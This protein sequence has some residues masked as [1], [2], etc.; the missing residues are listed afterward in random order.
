MSNQ[1][2]NVL[3][4]K[5][6]RSNSP[7]PSKDYQQLQNEST[8]EKEF[9]ELNLQIEK[10][11]NCEICKRDLRSTIKFISTSKLEFCT[12]C[13][14]SSKIESSNKEDY[15]VENKLNFPIFTEEWSASEEILLLTG[16]L[17]K[18]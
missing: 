17:F 1:G 7:S 8:N 10:K 6:A 3:R 2:Q 15:V 4:Q 11:S 13:F 9:I 5:R 18:N 14:I 16:K 12:N